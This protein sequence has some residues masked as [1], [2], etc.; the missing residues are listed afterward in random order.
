MANNSDWDLPFGLENLTVHR[1]HRGM[2]FEAMR[3]GSQKIPPGGQLYIY[4]VAPGAR[5]GDHYHEKKQEW[6]T[7]V[8]GQVRLLMKTVDGVLVDEILSH[9]SPR[10]VYAGPGT[11]HAVVNEEETEAV[12]VAYASKEFDPADPD[13]VMT[14]A[15]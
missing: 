14:P 12:I 7:C 5:R 9:D 13:T 15:D 8:A 4:S 11:S 6:F 2:L 3:F 1:D 10:M